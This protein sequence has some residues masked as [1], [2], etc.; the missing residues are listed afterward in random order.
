MYSDLLVSA[1]V[2]S[3]KQC[4]QVDVTQTKLANVI[5]CAFVFLFIS[6]RFTYSGLFLRNVALLNKPS[7]CISIS[8]GGQFDK[9]KLQYK[10][11]QGCCFF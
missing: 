8:K 1:D 11:F 7:V 9:K 3:L 10:T 2:P 4:F 5:V 6:E